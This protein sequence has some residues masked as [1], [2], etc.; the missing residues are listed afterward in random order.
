MSVYLQ[1]NRTLL[2]ELT[3]ASGTPDKHQEVKANNTFACHLITAVIRTPSWAPTLLFTNNKA[4]TSQTLALPETTLTSSTV[5]D[6]YSSFQP[7]EVPTATKNKGFIS[8][9]SEPYRTKE[10]PNLASGINWF[11][12]VT[13]LTFIA[14]T[15]PFAL[16][17][18]RERRSNHPAD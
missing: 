6:P 12:Q 5:C 14:C 2:A 18:E 17:W 9:Q 11:H 8:W 10:G 1:I 3:A 4:V 7:T 15:P 13:L 16:I